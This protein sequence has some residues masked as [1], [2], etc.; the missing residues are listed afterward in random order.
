MSA[1]LLKLAGM[2]GYMDSNLRL[3][4]FT[5]LAQEVGDW[6]ETQYEFDFSLNVP[7][8]PELEDDFIELQ[9]KKAILNIENEYVVQEVVEPEGSEGNLDLLKEL[10][11]LDTWLLVDLSRLIYLRNASQDAP[12]SLEM[13][14]R[15]FL[16]TR[17][18]FEEL[19]RQA[20]GLR[21]AV[22]TEG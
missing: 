15:F 13:A 19:V 14:R 12:V 3:H 11:R 21:L 16:M 22:V 5:Y 10:A 4:A 17:Q 18:K 6:T 9:K 20:R 8:S 2:L 7:F 1:G